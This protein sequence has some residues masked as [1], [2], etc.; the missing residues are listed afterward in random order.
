MGSAVRRPRRVALALLGM[1]LVVTVAVLAV[2]DLTGRLPGG[3]VADP[4]PTPTPTRALDPRPADAPAVLAAEPTVPASTLPSAVA[5]ALERALTSGALGPDPGAVVLDVTTGA[6]LLDRDGDR[7]RTPASVA[8]LATGAAA[9]TVLDPAG[10]LRTRVVS[11]AAPGEVVLVGAG[12]ATLTTAPGRDGG[13]PTR[14]SL[15]ALADEAVAS[16]R[17]DPAPGVEAVVTVRVDDSLFAGP[18]VS[19]DWPATYVGSGV[20]SPVSALSVDAGRTRRGSD[21]RESDPALA[22]GR[23]LVRLLRQRGLTV[24]DEVTRAPAPAAARQLAAVQSPTVSEMVELM[25]AESDN[26]LA[27]ALL[28]LVAVESGRPGTFVDGTAVVLDALAGLGVLAEGTVLLDG[29]GLARGSAVAPATLAGL[30]LRAADGSDPD[31]V[32]LAH[33]V[34]G[35]PVAGFTGTLSLRFDDGRDAAAEGLV[36]AKTGTLTGVST[37]AGVTSLTGRPVVF[38][39]M[40]DRVPGDTLAA[41]EALDRFAAALAVS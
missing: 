40:A 33:L 27:E 11:G 32:D 31:G 14:A 17:A 21:V 34:T 2:L 28:R 29:S 8:K 12:D 35:M 26:D 36:R 4:E 1:L 41:R 39:V 38:A 15:A 16:L 13:Y 7:P 25:L 18:A 6:R 37:L 5:G 22:A 23:E 20:V 10:R 3:L 19:P 30:L 24:A 9:V